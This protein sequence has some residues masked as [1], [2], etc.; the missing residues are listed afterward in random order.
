M[1]ELLIGPNDAGQRL[2]K[3]LSKAF[4]SLPASLLYKY[5]R[6]KRIKKNG[7]RAH[8][9]DRL[10][11]GDLL[12]LYINDELLEAREQQTAPL[13]IR[14]NLQV[15]YED[16]NLLIVDKPAGLLVHSDDKE[17]YHTL[18][19]QIQA[20]L[21][22]KGEYDPTRE[23][24]FAPALC[25]RLDRNTAGL[26][27]A[28]KNA[29]ALRDLNEIIKTRQM[30]KTY[31]ALV[32]GTPQPPEATLTGYLVRDREAARVTVLRH[33]A[34]GAK[35]I[36]TRYRVL[37]SGHGLSLVEIDLVT[38]RTHQIRAHFSS[39]GHPLYGDGKYGKTGR[40]QSP[41]YQ[42]LCAYQIRFEFKEY[43]GILSYLDKKQFFSAQ[44]EVFDSFS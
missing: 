43:K 44:T 35:S 25:N 42:A 33:P 27:V 20:Y 23:N 29:A 13:K 36:V 40:G 4:P 34:P 12:Q 1:K 28:A 31:L 3:F 38:G 15:V 39:I 2:D 9:D 10:C 21:Y 19:A 18:I 8:A 24:S 30:K 41:R 16:D 26:V 22:Q 32:C 11:E 14:P 7:A 17:S 6:L 37:R 5:L